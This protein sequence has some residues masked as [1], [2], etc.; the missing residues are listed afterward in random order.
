MKRTDNLHFILEEAWRLLQRGYQNPSSRLRTPVLA[1]SGLDGQANARTVVLRRVEPEKR[2][3]FINTDCRSPKYC[4]LLA[5]PRGTFVFFDPETK[6]QLRIYT[7]I[8]I[9]QHNELT[10]R[11]WQEL[12]ASGRKI[13]KTAAP[14]GETAP[15]PT[16]GFPMPE[17]THGSVDESIHTG[18]E[19]FVV[20]EAI[21]KHLDWLYFSKQGH[22]RAGFTW[23][24]E[25]L[26]HASWRYP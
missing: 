12:P 14:P 15:Q 23:D 5:D 13:Y 1:T 6:T 11:A 2:K 18:Y 8:Q 9:H 21:A 24:K 7:E 16:S 17:R 26:L 25:G 3:L 4:E 10:H 22:R 19:N 20:L